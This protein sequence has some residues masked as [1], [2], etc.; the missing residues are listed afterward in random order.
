MRAVQTNPGLTQLSLAY[1]LVDNDGATALADAMQ[2]RCATSSRVLFDVDVSEESLMIRCCRST[3]ARSRRWTCGTTPS[4]RPTRSGAS[5]SGSRFVARVELSCVVADVSSAVAPVLRG[6]SCCGSRG[7]RGT[8]RVF[9]SLWL[10]SNGG[11]RAGAADSKAASAAAGDD[12]AAAVAASSGAGAADSDA[13]GKDS[14]AGASFREESESGG[15]GSVAGASAVAAAA[16]G[17]CKVAG[18]GRGRG[19]MDPRMAALLED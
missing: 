3:T 18:A 9:V 16:A 12:K 11:A 2:V 4:R 19:R 5:R 17:E 15:S 1:N 14:G 8:E 10:Q 6:C 7:W 13:S